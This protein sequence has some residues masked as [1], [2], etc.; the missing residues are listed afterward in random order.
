LVSFEMVFLR[1]VRKLFR[2][3]SMAH[4]H[5]STKDDEV[6]TVQRMEHIL[7]ESNLNS[8][9]VHVKVSQDYFVCSIMLYS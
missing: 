1:K 8:K 5:P 3:D 4:V 6:I 7:R 9:S 2:H